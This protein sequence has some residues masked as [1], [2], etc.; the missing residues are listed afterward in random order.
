MYTYRVCRSVF[1][2]ILQVAAHLPQPA[3]RRSRSAGVPA[4]APAAADERAHPSQRAVRGARGA[5]AG[6]GHAAGA[7]AARLVTSRDGAAR[8]RSRDASVRRPHG[9]F[10][11][12][13]LLYL[14]GEPKG[15]DSSST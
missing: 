9:W 14:P 8:G 13:H 1:T 12:L 15:T 10:Y 7:G 5:A 11:T 3:R 2:F 6:G 4:P